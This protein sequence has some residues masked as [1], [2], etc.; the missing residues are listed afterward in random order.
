MNENKSNKEK[1]I[2]DAAYYKSLKR[3]SKPGLENTDWLEA[4]QE[5][6]QL[7][8]KRVKPGLVLIN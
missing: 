7:I 2:S 3:V 1:W 6:K 5:Y 4:E 8:R